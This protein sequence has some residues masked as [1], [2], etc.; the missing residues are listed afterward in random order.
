MKSISL[1]TFAPLMLATLAL[2][3]CDRTP[4]GLKTDPGVAGTSASF[5]AGSGSIPQSVT[6][7]GK[8]VPHALIPG[9]PDLNVTCA[10]GG[11]TVTG[12]AFDGTFIYV[13]HGG[14]S[15]SCITRYNAVTGAYVD[16]KNFRPDFRG[17]HWVSGLGKLVGRSYG[18]LGFGN[19][20]A[21]IGRFFSIDYAAGTGVLLTNYDVQP[22]NNQGQPGVDPDGLGYWINCGTALEHHR[23]SDGLLLNTYVTSPF[24]GG[25]NPVWA[26]PDAVVVPS[27][28]AN[29]YAIYDRATGT[30]QGNLSVITNNG[31]SGYGVGAMEQGMGAILGVNLDCTTV[32]LETGGGNPSHGPLTTYPGVVFT[33]HVTLCK[34]A[35]SPA[36]TY[37]FTIT[38]IGT[39]AG[40]VLQSGAQLNPGQC[41]IVFSRTAF[42]LVFATLTITEQGS[43][44]TVVHSITKKT[45]VGT[46]VLAGPNPTTMTSVNS[47]HGTVVT[48]KN[49]AGVP[50][51]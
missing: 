49:I 30:F 36:G 44:G 2:A 23:M 15:D 27:V 38:A 42:S 39:V 46:T 16:Q 22:C 12:I 8:L 45:L 17:L 6:D 9:F 35:S 20:A 7:A 33:S 48:Y 13:A 28:A 11:P 32:R 25:T 4:A 41:R 10:T 19:T 5:A 29:T 50:A 43:Q 40:D 14:F 21:E 47:D 31:C 26:G 51:G 1:R 37:N 34:D 18:G 24:F 3:A